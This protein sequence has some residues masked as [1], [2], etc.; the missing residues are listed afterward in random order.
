M[1]DWTRQKLRSGAS[2][3]FAALSTLA[4]E[5]PAPV[6]AAVTSPASETTPIATGRSP[7]QPDDERLCGEF[8]GDLKR[9]HRKSADACTRLIESGLFSGPK[10][11]TLLNNRGVEYD[12]LDDDKQALEDYRRATEINPLYGLAWRNTALSLSDLSRWQEAYDA[13]NKA[14]E[15][16]PNEGK[17]FRVRGR[18]LRNLGRSDEALEDLELAVALAPDSDEAH[19]TLG[20][21]HYDRGEF[22]IARDLFRLAIQLEENDADNHYALAFVL[23]DLDEN[24]EA[25]RAVNRSIELWEGGYYLNL[26]GFI[27]SQENH[28]LYDLPAALRDLRKAIE[29]NP[30]LHYPKYHLSAALALSGDAAG[31]LAML[32]EG[33]A[34]KPDNEKVRRVVRILF[35]KGFK[36]EAKQASGLLD[37]KQKK[38]A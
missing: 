13:A 20:W 29:L 4:C 17:S 33:H 14:V 2:L 27:L 35:Q 3:L 6:P 28:S 11:A 32:R 36:D 8:G 10:L 34:L 9:D 1:L 7:V 22:D 38:S 5:A 19:R 18:A 16:L 12:F 31:A 23:V 15:Y 21:V 26:R 30:D 37:S 25:L 24:E